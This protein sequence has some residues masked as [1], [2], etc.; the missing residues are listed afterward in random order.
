V[1]SAAAAAAAA[2]AAVAAVAVAADADDDDEDL[3]IVS[4]AA[5]PVAGGAGCSLA[6]NPKSQIL[7]HGGSAPSSS[8][9]SSLRSRWATPRSWSHA[10]VSIN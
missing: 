1:A 2:A 8:V 6:A 7:M 9:L 5:A 3:G 4:V 10:T